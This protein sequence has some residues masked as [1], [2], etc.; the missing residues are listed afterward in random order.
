MLLRSTC[1]RLHRRATLQAFWVCPL[2]CRRRICP[3]A[4][5]LCTRFTFRKLTRSTFSLTKSSDV[6]CTRILPHPGPSVSPTF[7]VDIPNSPQSPSLI[8]TCISQTSY[9]VVM[10]RACSPCHPTRSCYIALQ[11]ISPIP[12]SGAFEGNAG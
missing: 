2:I 11:S 6:Y 5:E 7:L 3:P 12:I 9:T 10:C 8:H 4:R 1:L